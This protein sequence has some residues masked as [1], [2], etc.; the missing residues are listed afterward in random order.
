[1]HDLIVLNYKCKHILMWY[2][3]KLMSIY[4]KKKNTILLFVHI[5]IHTYRCTLFTKLS[6]LSS[7]LCTIMHVNVS[8]CVISRERLPLVHIHSWLL[9]NTADMFLYNLIKSGTMVICTKTAYHCNGG[10]SDT[11]VV[12]TITAYHLFRSCKKCPHVMQG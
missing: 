1:M 2:L 10:T 6:F 8:T 5:S 3:F 12:C 7:L 4:L 11:M 9:M